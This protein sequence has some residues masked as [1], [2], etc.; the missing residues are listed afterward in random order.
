MAQVW[1]MVHSQCCFFLHGTKPCMQRTC[2]LLAHRHFFESDPPD[3]STGPTA[4]IQRAKDAMRESPVK[5]AD[6][7]LPSLGALGSVAF[8]DSHDWPGERERERETGHSDI[9]VIW[10]RRGGGWLGSPP[11]W[12]HRE[13]ST[14]PVC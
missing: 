14:Q 9:T 2:L 12:A 13:T 5:L 10:L 3:E 8:S 7:A 4:I 11:L 1:L 6:L